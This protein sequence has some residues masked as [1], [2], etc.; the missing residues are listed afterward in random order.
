MSDKEKEKRSKT[1]KERYSKQVHHSKGKD[2][3]NKGKKGVQKAWNKG[4]E[5]KKSECT[6]CKKM[7]DK[8]NG[9]RWHFDNC[10]LR[11]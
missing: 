5:A 4:L 10:K 3:W 6:H 2:P 9:K 8:G 11:K 1:L 7:V